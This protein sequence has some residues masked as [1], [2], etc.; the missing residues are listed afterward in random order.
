MQI[1][2]KSLTGRVTTLEVDPSDT[3]EDVKD[4]VSDTI[5]IPSS[6]QRLLFGGKQLED[7]HTLSDY[8]IIPDSTLHIVLRLRGGTLQAS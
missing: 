4:K 5:G 1:Y 6:E 8:N 7:G 2:V 3:I